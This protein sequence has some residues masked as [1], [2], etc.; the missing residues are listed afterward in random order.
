VG[1]APQ[2]TI[3]TPPP[4][5]DVGEVLRVLGRDYGI[6]GTMTPL[7]SER[8][9]NFR[10]VSADGRCFVV[11]IANVAE[12]PEVTDFQLQAL[13]HLERR[14]CPV[15]VP[16]LLQTLPGAVSTTIGSARGRHVLRVVSFVPGRPL[17][18]VAVGA[19]LAGDLGRALAQI[20]SALSDFSHHGQS[21][22]LL[23]DMQRAAELRELTVH[24]DDAGLRRR[25]HACL[26]DFESRC[27]PEFAGLRQQ[28]IHNDLNPGNV[29]VTPVAPLSVAGVID[30]GD[31]LRAPLVVDVAIAA[32]YLRSAHDG[33]AALS[34][35]VAGFDSVMPLGDDEF[36]L[37]YDLVRTRL[38]TTVIILYWRC[39]FRGADDPYL[40]QALAER[41]AER[42][43]RYLDEMPREAFH[44]RLR[45]LQNNSKSVT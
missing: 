37:L 35:F 15:P 2:D 3:L 19:G 32:S 40:R 41:G 21:Q 16:R 12:L 38:A 29:L 4:G 7:I 33:L 27:R 36:A 6:D 25:V 9:Q 18:G 45:L 23:W 17:D 22:A 24:L 39:S 10:L 13:L 30:F 43:L 11:K 20:D 31:M 26:D 28:V 42:F 8:D 34:A 1:L 5:F 14:A 44:S